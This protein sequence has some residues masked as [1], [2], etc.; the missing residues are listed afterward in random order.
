MKYVNELNVST[1]YFT[2]FIFILNFYAE[3][4]KLINLTRHI[5]SFSHL[6][7]CESVTAYLTRV[8]SINACCY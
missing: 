7:N 1:K 6:L 4:R 2:N 3:P 5:F 8:G